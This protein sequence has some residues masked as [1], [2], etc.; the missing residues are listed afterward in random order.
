MKYKPITL[1]IP[2]LG[3]VGSNLTDMKT[4]IAALSV[5]CIAVAPYFKSVSTWSDLSGLLFSNHSLSVWAGIVYAIVH[6]FFMPGNAPPPV[7]GDH[8]PPT[9]TTQEAK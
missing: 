3:S 6:A 2:D 4:N 8:T 7:A 9:S 1:N 5:L